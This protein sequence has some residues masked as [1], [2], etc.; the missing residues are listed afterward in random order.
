MVIKKDF[1]YS[2]NAF[3]GNL[4]YLGPQMYCKR[5]NKGMILVLVL[6]VMFFL[7]VSAITLAF[8]NRVNIRLR[9]LSN[10]KMRMLNFSK[11]ACN[12]A[13]AVL[14]DDDHNFDCLADLWNENFSLQKDTGLLSYKVIDEDSFI[15]INTVPELVL[16][17]IM[18]I[19]PDIGGEVID[20]II[21][22]RPFNL[23]REVIDTAGVDKNLFYGDDTAYNPGLKDLITVFSDG[24]LN[25]NTASR[26]VLMLVPT[27]NESAADAIIG[28]RKDNP[29]KDSAMLSADLS[30]LGLSAVQ[31]SELVSLSKI[32]SSVFRIK[33]E[34]VSAKKCVA[35][36]TEMIVRR[37]GQHFKVLLF[38]ECQVD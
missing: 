10:E 35:V 9:S 14:A 11:E 3:S 27:M 15:N 7:S 4:I 38:K 30:A 25:V 33:T 6:W 28:W 18:I 13:L 16:R 21:A 36:G 37:Q 29:F 19:F 26:N 22:S 1:C 5:Q 20:K 2:R 31:V 23:E 34:A 8:K 17:N 32:S 12:R 24:K